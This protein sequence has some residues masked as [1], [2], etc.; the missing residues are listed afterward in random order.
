[1]RKRGEVMINMEGI[2]LREEETKKVHK[3][4]I[5]EEGGLH[6]TPLI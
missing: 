2:L 3:I 5:L 4:I 1:M 6:I